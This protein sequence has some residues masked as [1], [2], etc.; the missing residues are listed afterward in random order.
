M[1]TPPTSPTSPTGRFGCLGTKECAR[2]LYHTE[3]RLVALEEDLK[4]DD[5]LTLDQRRDLVFWRRDL[6][7]WR[8]DL[9]LWRRD[10]SKWAGA[11]EIEHLQDDFRRMMD[12]SEVLMSEAEIL[13]NNRI[14]EPN[15]HPLVVAVIVI[16]AFGVVV[17]CL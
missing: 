7:F 12:E 16:I 9:V 4:N 5:G 8:R 11:D 2:E 1:T 13:K 17:L 3:E 15:L 10:L 14:P 6:V